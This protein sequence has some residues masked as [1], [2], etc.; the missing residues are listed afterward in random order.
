MSL[1]FQKRLLY[2]NQVLFFNNGD[3]FEVF[4]RLIYRGVALEFMQ[5]ILGT[6]YP[7]VKRYRTQRFIRW[8]KIVFTT[9]L[10]V[11]QNVFLS[12]I[13]IEL[14][15][16]VL[17][18]IELNSNGLG[19]MNWNLFGFLVLSWA[20][21]FMV[22][23]KGIKS[24]GKA[25]YVFAILPYVVLFTLLIKALTLEGAIDGIIFF[26]KPQWEKLLVVKVWCEA[27]QQVFFSLNVFFA[28][29]IMYSSHNKFSHNVYRDAQIVTTL[30]TFTSLLAGC[31]V[32]G[33]LG[34]NLLLKF[35]LWACL[36]PIETHLKLSFWIISGHLAHELKVDVKTFSESGGP[37]LA[38]ISYP[39]TI[40]KFKNF[41][42]VFSTLFFLMLYFLRIGSNVAMTQTFVTVVKESFKNVEQWKAAMGFAIFV[43]IFGS[44]YLTQVQK[45]VKQWNF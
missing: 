15:K 45:A 25:S 4:P 2:S 39:E 11:N 28:S 30:D 38:F 17:N 13:K 1:N 16:E 6:M 31:V 42:Q 7:C 22:V 27:I 21:V 3:S 19:L 5:K 41:P 18:E 33:I 23:S 24:S 14:S 8:H 9:L 40:A 29:V 44:I 32:F 34:R 20:L 43:T 12:L 35:E 10:S 37:G 26:F 36:N